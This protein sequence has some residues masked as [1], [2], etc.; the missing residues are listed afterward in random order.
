MSPPADN[1][2]ILVV[3]DDRELVE[4][5]TS[6]L[7]RLG[8]NP[9][10][11]YNGE[12]ALSIY[13]RENFEIV[14]TDIQMPKRD[15]ME[16]LKAIK[17]RNEEAIVLVIT[18]YGTIRSAVEAIKAGAFDFIQKPFQLEELEIILNKALKT[19]ELFQKLNQ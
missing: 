19:R 10:P 18:G 5:I 12:E 14:I 2:S 3:D 13:E 17:E 7:K 16:L 1:I 4:T 9:T 11:A 15:G 6:S 8:F